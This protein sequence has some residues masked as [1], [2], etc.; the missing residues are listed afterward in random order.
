[1]SRHLASYLF[2]AASLWGERAACADASGTH[3]YNDYLN[4]ALRVAVLLRRAGVEAGDRVCISAPKSFSLYASL[5]GTLMLNACYVPIDYTVPAGRGRKIIAD[6]APAALIT[7]K[8]NLERLLGGKPAE[9]V[10]PD[11]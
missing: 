6:C 5:F 7:T 8:R 9:P 11:V 1:M 3:S 4:E 2:D 10:E